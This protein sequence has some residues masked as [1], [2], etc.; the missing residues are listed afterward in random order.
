MA[1]DTGRKGMNTQERKTEGQMQEKEGKVFL[2]FVSCL[3]IPLRSMR[4]ENSAEG[5]E[6]EEFLKVRAQN[7]ETERQFLVGRFFF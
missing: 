7:P 4:K 3:M 5:K 6:L 1:K 2:D